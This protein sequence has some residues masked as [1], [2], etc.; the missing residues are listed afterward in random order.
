MTSDNTGSGRVK[1][2]RRLAMTNVYVK[3]LYADGSDWYWKFLC[4]VFDNEA[5]GVLERALQTAGIACKLDHVKQ[6]NDV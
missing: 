6:G 3:F 1:L 4:V 2:L 5:L